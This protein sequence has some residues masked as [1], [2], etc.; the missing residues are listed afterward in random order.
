MSR[1]IDKIIDDVIAKEGGFVDHKDDRGGATNWGITEAVARANGWK[2]AMRD[3]PRQ[4]AVDVY[5]K[6]YVEQPG[7]AKVAGI[8][9]P[10]AAELVDTGVNMGPSIA[11]QILQRALNVL[12]RQGNDY[13]DIARD[14]MIGPATLASLRAFLTKRGTLGER[15]LLA[16]L[17]AL[18]G[19]RYVELAEKRAAN[20]SF[21][22]GWLER[23][24]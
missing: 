24:A 9:E 2:G 18:Q 15:R 19:A 6:R 21:M 22:F 20:E 13:P 8:S 3:M 11:A 1:T 17:N 7:F 23:I 16:L 12:N 14:G 5:R 10:I 4:F